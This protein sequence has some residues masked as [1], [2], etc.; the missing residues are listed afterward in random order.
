MPFQPLDPL[1][2]ERCNRPR[3][4]LSVLEA[5]QAGCALVLGDID[6]L[7]ELW[8]GAATFVPERQALAARAKQRSLALTPERMA[9]QYA[10]LYRE[11]RLRGARST[12]R[13]EVQAC[14]S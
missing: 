13:T 3:V 1:S 7:R 4:G 5:A 2:A 14:A 9:S 12:P 10:A 11:L 6:S 8:D